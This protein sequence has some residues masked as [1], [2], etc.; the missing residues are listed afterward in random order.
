MTSSV[1]KWDWGLP[2]RTP[3]GRREFY[4]SRRGTIRLATKTCTAAPFWL[5]VVVRTVISPWLGRDFD[6]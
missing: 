6:G 2:A 4:L 3:R 1:I 5:S